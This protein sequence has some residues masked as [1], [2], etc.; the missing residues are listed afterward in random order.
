MTDTTQKKTSDLV[1]RAFILAA[2]ALVAVLGAVIL[3]GKRGVTPPKIVYLA[4]AIAG[5]SVSA[6]TN[7][8]QVDPAA[9][10]PAP[11][12][13]T[14]SRTGVEDF[15]P[16]PDGERIAY[17]LPGPGK[18]S[19]LHLVEL[20]SGETRPITNC[21]AAQAACRA[22]AWSPD[23][24]RLVYERLEKNPDLPAIDRD[25]P[26]AWIVNLSDLSTA[27]M[28]E[29]PTALG[30]TPRWSPDGKRIAVFDLSAGG[31]VVY[32]LATG[33]RMIVPSIEAQ[34]GDYAFSPDGARLVYPQLVD[35]G[36]R[37]TSRLEMV[38]LDDPTQTITQLSGGDN[39]E[40][41]DK[42][43]TWRADSGGGRL[44]FTRRILDG[45][46]AL[47]PQIYS[48]DPET[49]RIEPLIVDPSYF[50]GGLAWDP[51]GEWLALQRARLSDPDPRP[52]IWLFDAATGEA[53][54]LVENAYAPRWI[55]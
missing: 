35:L 23:G 37:F 34:S 4:P 29:D 12:Q 39:L 47:A 54:L 1:H 18:L 17:T 43:P 15:Q 14:F 27:P 16:S 44:T 7:I 30:G 24:R 40:V 2:L 36:A 45:S 53:R 20:A 9:P 55:P 42:L 31:I 26:R 49:G 32:E 41:E 19:D 3:G 52:D 8:W 5:N 48:V 25:V 13:V 46:G 28:V 50:H 21:A 33:A 10:V 6:V 11:H 38:E 22:P 51:R